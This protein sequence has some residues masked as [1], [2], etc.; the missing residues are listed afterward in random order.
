MKI[1]GKK[2]GKAIQI[3]PI[4]KRMKNWAKR[5]P[6]IGKLSSLAKPS[7]GSAVGE[8]DFGLSIPTPRFGT[9]K[10]KL[11]LQ[12]NTLIISGAS[13]VKKGYG[14]HRE[15]LRSTFR[16]TLELPGDVSPDSIHATLGN[17]LLQVRFSKRE[18]TY[19]RLLKVA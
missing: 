4:I 7:T 8:D 17:G 6:A 18:T 14:I 11:E 19:R 1:L 5:V 16:K 15:Y 13:E 9:D 12:G 2:V 10:V 3:P